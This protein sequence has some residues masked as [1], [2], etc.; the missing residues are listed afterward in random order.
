MNVYVKMS[1]EGFFSLSIYIWLG[2]ELLAIEYNWKAV[3]VTEEKT[4][5]QQVF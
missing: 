1:F 4:K 2:I 5:H 3:N